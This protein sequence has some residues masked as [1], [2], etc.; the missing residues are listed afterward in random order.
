MLISVPAVMTG[1]SFQFLRVFAKLRKATI[2]FVMS[3]CLSVCLS[4][5]MEQLGSHWMDFHEIWYLSTFPNSFAKIKV[6]FQSGKNSRY[7]TWRP[8][9][10]FIVPCSVLLRMWN[11]SEK[12]SCT[13]NQ[14]TFYIQQPI[15][16]TRSLYKITWENIVEPGRAGHT[17]DNMAHVLCMLDK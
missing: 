16:Q 1:K 7:C 5:R 13:Q 12:N 14:N 6:S 15:L 10:I 3:V 4:V 8:M 17:D 11:V 9:Y 2:S